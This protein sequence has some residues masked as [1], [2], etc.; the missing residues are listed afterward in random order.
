VRL[1]WKEADDVISYAFRS[2]CGYRHDLGF[3]FLYSWGDTI[4]ATLEVLT[5]TNLA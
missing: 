4:T 5:A 3:I 1:I 2:N